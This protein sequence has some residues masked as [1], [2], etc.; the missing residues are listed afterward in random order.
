MVTDFWIQKNSSL[1]GQ[2]RPLTG[3]LEALTGLFDLL[4]GQ[5]HFLTDQLMSSFAMIVSPKKEKNR[6]LPKNRHRKQL[7]VRR[8]S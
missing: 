4:T 2:L 6:Q 5:L 8:F 1:T 3:Q 7:T